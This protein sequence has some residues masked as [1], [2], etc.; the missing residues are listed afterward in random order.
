MFDIVANRGAKWTGKLD[1]KEYKHPTDDS[2]MEAK[3]ID[4]QTIEIGLKNPSGPGVTHMWQVK[5]DTLIRT[6]VFLGPQARKSVQ[7]FE[8]I[9]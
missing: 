2:T 1:G 6:L 7:N 3:R 5:G 8:R 4:G 9:K